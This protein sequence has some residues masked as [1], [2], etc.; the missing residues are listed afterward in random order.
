[1]SLPKINGL[2]RLTRD[3][4]LIY[5]QSGAGILKLGLAS[6]EKYKDK[7]TQ[8][9]ID[10]VAFGKT[11]EIINQYAGKKGTQ[12]FLSG[13]IQTDSWEKEGKKQYKTSMVVESF[14][15]VSN[16]QQNQAPQQQAQQ[17]QAPQQQAQQHQAPQKHT[18]YQTKQVPEIDIDENDSLP[19]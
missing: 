9:F 15:F 3:A 5:T 12:I 2:F 7:E 6:S 16:K 19:F 11:G 4:E 13:K 18:D 17:N 8:L 1:M 14:D 10:A